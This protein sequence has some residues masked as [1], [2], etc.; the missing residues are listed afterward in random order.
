MAGLTILL[1]ISIMSVLTE[2]S[3][4][5]YG[6]PK[7]VITSNRG[8]IE[9]IHLG[10]VLKV[11]DLNDTRDYIYDSESDSPL[12]RLAIRPSMARS[13]NLEAHHNDGD[14]DLI[15]PADSPVTV[16]R[17]QRSVDKSESDD[18]ETAESI[19]FRPLFVYRQQVAERNRPY[20]SENPIYGSYQYGPAKSY[21]D[22]NYKKSQRT[23]YNN[24]N[25]L[26]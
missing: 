13:I 14:E 16:I 19:V 4:Q 22:N 9:R 3:V 2:A 5:A 25:S 24:Y 17:R 26:N 15:Q 6:L 21:A 23:Y 8:G 1:L 7:K 18:L 20:K 12:I 10:T 11:S